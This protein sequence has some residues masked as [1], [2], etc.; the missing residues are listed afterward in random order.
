MIPKSIS[1]QQITI[2]IGYEFLFLN[3]RISKMLWLNENKSDR[4]NFLFFFSFWLDN[5][6]YQCQQQQNVHTFLSVCCYVARHHLFTYK[7]TTKQNK[8]HNWNVK[9]NWK[10]HIFLLRFVCFS[11]P[12]DFAIVSLV[13]WRVFVSFIALLPYC[14]YVRFISRFVSDCHQCIY[15]HVSRYHCQNVSK[16]HWYSR[17]TFHSIRHTSIFDSFRV[18]F[19]LSSH[20][21]SHWYFVVIFFISFFFLSVSDQELDWIDS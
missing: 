12:F 1:S 10:C 17:C 3:S 6:Q 20:S 16:W 9:S 18:P 21:H 14:R 7:L 5:N 8:D 19:L 11:I 4:N 13:W 2:F 15:I